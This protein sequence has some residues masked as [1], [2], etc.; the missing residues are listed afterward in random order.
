MSTAAAAAPL[1]LSIEQKLHRT[2][3]KQRR[4]IHSRGLCHVL[5]WLIALVLLDLLVDWLFRVPGYARLALPAVNIALLAWVFHTRWW[6]DLHPFDEVTTALQIERRHPEFQSLLVS[7]VQ[8]REDRPHANC[9]PA[10]V[11]A[12]RRQTIEMTRPVSFREIV[13]FAELKRIALVSLVVLLAFSA[14][15]VNWRRHFQALARRIL[16][17]Q[18]KIDYP[19]R[20]QIVAVTGDVTIQQGRPVTIQAQAAGRIPAKGILYVT[21]LGGQRER[22]VLPQ[23]KPGQFAYRFVEVLDSFTYYLWLGDDVSD[24]HTVTVVAP[25]RILNSRVTLRYPAYTGLRSPPPLDRLN[26]E[27]PEGTRIAWELTAEVPIQGTAERRREVQARLTK[28]LLRTEGAQPVSLDLDPAR[29]ILRHAFTAT[30]SL[31]YQFTWHVRV[32]DPDAPPDERVRRYVYD[33]DIRYFILVV[34]DTRPR[35]QLTY[36]L[37]D[38]KATVRK[39]LTIR[40]RALDD[41]GLAH[42]KIVYSL[43]DGGEKTIPAASLKTKSADEE[44]V[45]K[46]RDDIPDLAVDDVLTYA[47]EVADRYTG[48]DGPHRTRSQPRRLYIVSIEEYRRHI[49]EKRKKLRTELQDLHGQETEADTEVGRILKYDEDHPKKENDEPQPKR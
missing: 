42:A 14:I 44:V 30:E 36:P 29:S 17:P 10:L 3:R 40:F 47:V 20:T 15:S 28:A 37:Q 24:V 1:T 22:L 39:T 21:P 18:A 16:Y 32:D 27:V 2:W 5:L 11:R 41:Y 45:W 31:A 6:R 13:N 38:D 33:D 35:V 46:L 43:A 7:S 12:F 34:P 48:P 26:F 23:G 9:S 19:T 49:L 4:F 8:L 25:P